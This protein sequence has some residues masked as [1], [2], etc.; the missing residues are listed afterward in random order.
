MIS[1]TQKIRI[2]KALQLMH[3]A[4]IGQALFWLHDCEM[5]V[6][7]AIRLL[8]RHYHGAEF[9]YRFLDLST[10]LCVEEVTSPLDPFGNI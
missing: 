2:C 8:S 7:I 3:V 5:N 1:E 4:K 6:E 10:T 9:F